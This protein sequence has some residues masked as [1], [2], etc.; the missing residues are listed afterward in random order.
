MAAFVDKIQKRKD[1]ALSCK[2]LFLDNHL[3]DLTVSQ[4]ACTAG[5]GKGTIYEYFTNKEDIVFEIITI[6]MEESNIRKQEKIAKADSTKDKV[7]VFFEFYY[8]DESIELRTIYKEF[9]SISLINPCQKMLDFQT[10]C[11]QNYHDWISKIIQNGVDKGEIIP[12]STQL[13]KGIFEFGT[14]MFITN[15]ITNSI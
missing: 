15:E 2:K 11:H 12:Q 14:G 3:A 8:A 4:I 9:I 1:I 13:I 5:I 7:K 10:N 6:L